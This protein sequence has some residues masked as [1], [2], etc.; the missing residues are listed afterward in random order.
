MV[1][2]IT[3]DDLKNWY[4]Y[5]D[6]IKKISGFEIIELGSFDSFL[7]P[8]FLGFEVTRHEKEVGEKLNMKIKTLREELNR[9]EENLEKLEEYA[10]DKSDFIKECVGKASEWKT[11]FLGDKWF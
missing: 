1:E 4:F 5:L 10:Y 6:A 8:T 2:E 9:Y 3:K 7:S 11:K